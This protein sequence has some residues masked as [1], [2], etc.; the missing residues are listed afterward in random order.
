MKRA[1]VKQR[2]REVVIWGILIPYKARRQSGN[3]TQFEFRD[4]SAFIMRYSM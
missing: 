2:L 3:Q 1:T 4:L